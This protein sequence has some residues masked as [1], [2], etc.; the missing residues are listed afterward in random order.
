VPVLLGENQGVRGF[1]ESHAFDEA[2]EGAEVLAIGRACE[3]AGERV[4]GEPP[5]AV[6]ITT[7]IF[8]GGQPVP[9]SW[10]HA[11]GRKRATVGIDVKKRQVWVGT[12]RRDEMQ[13]VMR[14]LNDA[15][16]EAHGA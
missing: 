5:C 8:R 16:R 4:P 13:I 11:R 6:V 12:L 10:A 14:M 7:D 9:I 2:C 3:L 15:W 1:V